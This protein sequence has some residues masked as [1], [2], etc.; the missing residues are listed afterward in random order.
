MIDLEADSQNLCSPVW[1]VKTMELKLYCKY[2]RPLCRLQVHVSMSHFLIPS[3][4]HGREDLAQE[5]IRKISLP[6]FPYAL[7]PMVFKLR[8]IAE[9]ISRD[10]DSVTL[11][12]LKCNTRILQTWNSGVVFDC[13]SA[14]LIWTYMAWRWHVI[15]VGRQPTNGGTQFPP[16]NQFVVHLRNPYQVKSL[17]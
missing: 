9:L 14:G 10:S 3:S 4:L 5:C 15:H 2:Q 11:N 13:C 16:T 1:S 6:Q 8:W 7:L 12:L 17:S